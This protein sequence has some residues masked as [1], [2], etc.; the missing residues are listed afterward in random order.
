[1]QFDFRNDE[2]SL[3]ALCIGVY[4]YLYGTT[5]MDL[6]GDIHKLLANLAEYRRVFPEDK[7]FIDELRGKLLTKYLFKPYTKNN[8]KLTWE[9]LDLLVN[10]LEATGDYIDQIP[11]FRNFNHNLEDCLELT[12]WFCQNSEKYLGEYTINLEKYIE[13]NGPSHIMEEDVIFYHGHE[14]EYH[15][16]MLGAEIMN[17]IYR[18]EYG[19]RTRKAILLPSCMNSNSKKCQAKEDML[20]DVCTFCNPKCK[21]YQISKKY[22]NH[23]V[24][25]ISHESTAFRNAKKED[26]DELG[27]IGITCVLNLISGGWKAR[28]LSIPPQCVLLEH[29]ACKN[30]WLDEDIYG[31]IDKDELELKL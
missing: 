8:E 28:N 12:K 26:K 14:L 30:H 6:N 1:M 5:A 3:E 7:P 31:E 25:I 4:W 17:R 24:Y 21:V 2:E 15:L 23:E 20:G 19:S 9:N 27:I 10:F 13:S 29:V 22:Q 16:N 18:E 11:H